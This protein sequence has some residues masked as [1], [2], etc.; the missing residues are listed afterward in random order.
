MPAF[1]LLSGLFFKE[2]AK[3][4]SSK[5]IIKKRF[6]Q[7]MIPYLFFLFV[8]TAIRY[9]IEIA[10]GNFDFSWYLQDLWKLVIAGVICT[11]ALWRIL[12]YHY[13]IFHVFIVYVDDKV[14][15]SNKTNYTASSILLVAHLESIFTMHVIGG[16]SDE[17]AQTIPMLWNIDVVLLTVVYFAIGYYAKSVLINITLPWLLS[18]ITVA[19]GAIVANDLGFIDY[20]LSLKFL[21]YDHLLLDLIIP[22]S[23]IVMIIGFFQRITKIMPLHWLVK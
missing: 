9:S 18:A 14:F 3:N 2:I 15:K 6:M 19:V 7:L 12:V 17:A 4:E 22:I 8:I 23:F 10:T 1:F 13:I 21:R 16:A 5:A 11:R 20:H